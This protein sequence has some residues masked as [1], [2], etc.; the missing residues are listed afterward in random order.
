MITNNH[1]QQFIL[2][3]ENCGTLADLGKTMCAV[4]GSRDFALLQKCAHCTDRSVWVDVDIMS[5][6]LVSVHHIQLVATPITDPAT[7]CDFCG[8]PLRFT[9]GVALS[10]ECLESPIPKLGG[11]LD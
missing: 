8:K 1:N 10:C 7:M 9:D 11:W 4:C 3:C 5:E 2:G 6:H